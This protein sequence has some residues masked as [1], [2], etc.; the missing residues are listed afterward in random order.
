M[1]LIRHQAAFRFLIAALL[2]LAVAPP[3][4]AT[5]L[6]QNG[7]ISFD[8][9]GGDNLPT[10]YTMNRD[11]TGRTPIAPGGGYS[12]WSADGQRV[13]YACESFSSTTF[14]PANTCTADQDG[15]DV[16]VLDNFGLTPQWRP[17]WSPD[18]RRLLID[19]FEVF[20]H[21]SFRTDVW[22]ID[23]ADGGD[24]IAMAA[25]GSSG[26]WSPNGQILY[27]EIGGFVSRV[28]ANSPNVS[29]QL[30]DS[31]ADG[32][33]DWSPD[34]TKVV[35]M[36]CRDGSCELYTMNA[37]GS[38]E[39]EVP[40]TGSNEQDPVWSPD[41][42]KILFHRSGDL[43]LVNP[44]G[45]GE[46]NITNTPGI[47]ELFPAWQPDPLPGYVRPKSATPLRVPLVPAFEPCESPNRTHGPPLAFGSCAP[48]D[49]RGGFMTFGAAPPGRSP[50]A[51]GNVRLR[52]IPGQPGSADEADV[53]ISVHLTDVRRG[54]D[55][56]DGPGSLDFP[57]P[58]RL[59][60]KENGAFNSE[61]ATVKDFNEG[62]TGYINNPLRV[63]VPC[64]ETA[65]PN[66]GSTCSVTTTA[67]VILSGMSGQRP[68][69]REGKRAIWQLGQLAVYD[70]GEDGYIE[71]RDDNTVLAVQGVFVP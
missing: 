33:P 20:G 49:E 17:F 25:N 59:T 52:V 50:Q 14:M 16:T 18:G 69:V 12:A 53:S 35:F 15:S 22:R 40:N 26:T 37:D 10:V 36:S 24:Q 34:G 27:S 54:F 45:T 51:S 71:S 19:N 43:Y 31:G 9:Y 60:D 48:P 38:N 39:T 55:L 13:A 68:F 58:L 42:S 64:V 65:D 47:S 28:F 32:A 66:V 7:K 56:A 67:D 41:G 23:S 5:Y 30:T 46:T 70:G 11:G 3:A 61:Q 44:D 29:T 6:G 1:S 4:H 2:A 63:E 57:L 21:G 8:V 62:I